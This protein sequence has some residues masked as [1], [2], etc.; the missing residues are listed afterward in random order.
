MTDPF[1]TY[2]ACFTY[3]N[4]GDSGD[5]LDG[6]ITGAI[7]DFY[8][9]SENLWETFPV[10]QF[11]EFQ[12]AKIRNLPNWDEICSRVESVNSLYTPNALRYLKG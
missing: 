12:A 1:A 7:L 5:P 8:A 2:A 3:E 10:Q 4:V 11:F 9:G 6:R